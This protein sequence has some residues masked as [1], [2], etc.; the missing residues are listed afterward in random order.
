MTIGESDKDKL[1]QYLTYTVSLQRVMETVLQTERTLQAYQ[2]HNGFKVF[3][4]KYVQII[5]LI[6]MDI[7]LPQILDSYDVDN[8]PG[9]GHML[10]YQRVEIFESVY[11]NLSI[12]RAFLETK[13][14]TVDDEI[15][16]L[17]DFIQSRLRSAVFAV[18]GKE[19]DVQ[20]VIEQLL[21]G[22]G[23]QKGQD[24]DREVGRVKISA[25]EAV[26]DFIMTRLSLAIEVK[27]VKSGERVKKVVDE[28]SADIA[29][30]SKKYR[31]L[32]FLIYD[33][34]FIRDE[35]EFRQDLDNANN[36]SVLVIKH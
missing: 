23:M 3:A 29:S 18:P 22:R 1:R 19:L 35:I 33:L 28:I 31:R 25:K 7:K 26:P 36:I 16:V 10:P 27:L 8:I 34:G 2:Q 32:L 13:I 21:I 11:A 17:R 24:Y 15:L 14:G 5:N 6:G 12:L 20:N 30:Y 9:P 4:R